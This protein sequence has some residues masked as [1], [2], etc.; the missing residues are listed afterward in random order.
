MFEISRQAQ[1][2]SALID[3]M[4]LNEK[5][6]RKNKKMRE[7]RNGS[8]LKN[9]AAKVGNWLERKLKLQPQDMIR[10]KNR[11]KSDFETLTS[12]IIFLN[13]T[14]QK[15]PQQS[16]YDPFK[17][18]ASQKFIVSIDNL[19]EDAVEHLQITVEFVSSQ[20]ELLYCMFLHKL[21][22]F[23]ECLLQRWLLINK[24]KEALAIAKAGLV[25][26]ETLSLNT[27]RTSKTKKCY[28]EVAAGLIQNFDGYITHIKTLK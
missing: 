3:S 25:W 16:E 23:K 2:V 8:M 13:K 1:D 14:L 7:N 26:S 5:A 24:K 6:L 11:A 4:Y 18:I 20:S 12:S 21:C 9:G 22:Q 19:L 27:N 15:L 28:E 10:A 17:I